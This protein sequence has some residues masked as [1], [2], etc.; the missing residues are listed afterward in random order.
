MGLTASCRQATLLL[1]QHALHPLGTGDR[2]RLWMHQRICSACR[3]YARQSAV[4][5]RL[6]RERM[7]PATD[8]TALEERVLARLPR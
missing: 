8:T 5:D 7:A 6:L 2:L 1:E 4:I 3:T